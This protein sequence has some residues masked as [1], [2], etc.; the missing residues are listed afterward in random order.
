MC[1][2]QRVSVEDGAFCCLW[3]TSA[4]SLGF[5]VVLSELVKMPGDLDAVIV[6]QLREL[7]ADSVLAHEQ[8]LAAVEP[9]FHFQPFFFQFGDLAPE[10]QHFV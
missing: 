4:F 9:G 2:A 1:P 8:V 3:E 10:L 5:R 7:V 6:E